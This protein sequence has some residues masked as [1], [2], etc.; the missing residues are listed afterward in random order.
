[1]NCFVADCCLVVVKEEVA[2]CRIAHFEA[3][4]E[5][6]LILEVGGLSLVV[7]RVASAQTS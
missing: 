2:C 1:M 4:N 5:F 3:G 7:G 6:G